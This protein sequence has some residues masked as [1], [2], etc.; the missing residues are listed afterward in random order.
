MERRD[1][2]EL[3]LELTQS[4]GLSVYYEVMNEVSYARE[5]EE[6][7]KTIDMLLMYPGDYVYVKEVRDGEV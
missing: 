7:A 4:I 6:I 3:I 1:K 5:R 2:R